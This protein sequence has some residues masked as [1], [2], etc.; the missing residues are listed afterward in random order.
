MAYKAFALTNSS[1]LQET[2]SEITQILK[3]KKQNSPK[4]FQN[5]ITFKT[6]DLKDI[7]KLA[8]SSQSIIKTGLLLFEGKFKTL[9]ELK[10]K[11][12]KI[13]LKEFTSQSQN[14]SFAVRC[15]KQNIDIPT[16]QLEKKIGAFLFQNLEKKVKNLK[17]DLENPDIPFFAYLNKDK[18]YL[19]IDFSGFEL[20]KRDYKIFINPSD[21]KGNIAFSLLKFANYNPTMKLLDPFCKSA[22]LA[23]EAALFI[24][25]KSPHFFRKTEFNFLKLTAFKNVDFDKFF[26][27]IDS[28]NKKQ[29]QKQIKN[30]IFAFDSTLKN[31]NAARKN[32]K[33]AEINKLITFSKTIPEDLDLKF[34][35]EIDLIASFPTEINKFNE[36]ETNKAYKDLFYQADY[37]LSK[38]ANIALIAPKK[39]TLLKHAEFYGLKL[40]KEKQVKTG[41]K[42]LFFLLFAKNNKKL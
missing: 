11:L 8:Y 34:K 35:Q 14:I 21:V 31:I 40:V 13:N 15:K 28:K 39:E 38:K 41:E 9:K 7:C 25:N 24:S 36:K 42:T 12:K 1:I 27:S 29:N 4:S 33:I 20:D 2:I 5:I 16:K 32:A 6:N 26:K 30:K 10:P 17:V 3:L 19:G 18:I 23:I 22:T 37:I